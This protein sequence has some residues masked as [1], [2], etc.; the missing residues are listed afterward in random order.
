[1]AKAGGTYP[2]IV[3]GV[4]DKKPH[5]RRPGQ[6]SEQVNML[7]DPVRG[8]VRRRG[9]RFASRS[10]I[11][12]SEAARAE[13]QNMD[14]FDF[15]QNGRDYA[16]LYRREASALGDGSFAFLYD[17]TAEAF[18]PLVYENSTWVDNLVSGGASS[19]VAVGSYVYIAGNTTI[20]A[21]TSVNL[22]EQP[23]NQ[24]R[25]A[26]WI[27]T[28]K[29]NTTYTVTLHRDDGTTLEVTYKT[30]AA[31]Y[32]GTLDTS[33]IPFYLPD[34]TTPDPEYQKH[35]NDRVNEYNSAVNEWIVTSAE[36]IRPEN[37]AEKLT[38]ELL[39]AGVAATFVKGGVLVDDSEF[40][41]ITVD[42]EGDGTTFYAAGKEITDATRA[43]KYHFHGKIIR[44][45]PSGAGDD[46]A[47]YLRAELE[48]GET[49]GYGAVDWFETAGVSASVDTFVSQLFIHA[50]TGYIASTG[51]GLE[52]LAPGS[53]EHPDFASRAVG[54]GITSPLPYFIGRQITML[55][56]FQDR[57]VVGSGNYVNASKS[58]DYLNFFRG[59]VVTIADNDPIEVFAFGS[60]GDVL[61]HAVLY[62]GSLLIFGDRQQYG[63]SGEQ[64]FTPKSPL[65]KAVSANKDSTDAKA[66]ASGNFIFYSQFGD[67]GTS[68][69]QMRVA[70]LSGQATVTDELSEELDT[71]LSG[72]PLQ[73]VTLT[74]PNYVLLRTRDKPSGFYLYRY[75]DNKNNGQRMVSS[76]HRFQ[77]AA[78]L[79]NIVGISS[80]KKSGIVFTARPEGVVADIADFNADTPRHGHLDSRVAYIDRAQAGVVGGY[81][82]AAHTSPYY[83]LGAPEAD[84]A[85]F[86]SQFDDL[87]EAEL[88][89]G[90]VSEAW[91]IPT[92]PYP[93]DRNGEPV[94]DGLMSLNVVTADVDDT[95]GM[96][97]E[98][99]T[100]NGTTRA[101]DFE[102][103]IL[104]N[105]DNLIGRQPLFTGQLA[106]GVGQEVRDCH[107]VLR[108][109]DWLPLRITGLLWTGQTFNHVRR[110]S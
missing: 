4:S 25:L 64:L 19:L 5:R 43:V 17:K 88:E 24:Q 69:H 86:L 65:I 30:A 14:V 9:T 110:V 76:W 93:R 99:V 42:D 49:T 6:A 85:D 68:L 58:G 50:G 83:L 80:H 2:D 3:Q 72:A 108:S 87:T 62:N 46:E 107:Y 105:S 98:V 55:S 45:R 10:D 44:V 84:V 109:K 63:I 75:E 8:L 59:S 90:A 92:N 91:V 60:E 57:L 28:G 39:L 33:D 18:I 35:V 71:W 11:V 67:D 96:V 77:Y 79:G 27:R 70:A 97:A 26:G 37:I 31:S 32:P 52:S 94:L 15:T 74:A 103:R 22:W 89:Y 100:K 73:I 40:V 20:P 101:T 66:Q 95:G 13:L 34:G 12:L 48:S 41:D 78:A 102:G 51:A 7:P 54:D 23:T 47:Y 81:A 61:R 36:D 106:F 29:Y 56:V 21:A 104:G 38:D 16:L 53:G 82:V 1:M